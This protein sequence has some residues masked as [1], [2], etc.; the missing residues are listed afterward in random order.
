MKK[1]FLFSTGFLLLTAFVCSCSDEQ[2]VALQSD[3]NAGIKQML[4]NFN[5]QSNSSTRSTV[6]NIQI[7][8]IERQT[9]EMQGD[10]AV[11]VNA[12]VRTQTAQ[13]GA[14]TTFDLAY[15]S[16][17]IGEKKGF[18][19]LSDDERLNRVFFFTPNGCVADTAN[20][21]ALKEYLDYIPQFVAAEIHANPQ[22]VVTQQATVTEQI[23]HIVQTKWGQGEPFNRC[24]S[25]CA[26]SKCTNPNHGKIIPPIGCVN[27]AVAQYIAHCGKFLGTFY[28]NR[29]IDFKSL[30]S[31][32]YPLTINERAICARFLHEI[33]LCCQTYFTC[34]ASSTSAKA[35]YYYLRDLT[36]DCSYAEGGIDVSRLREELLKGYPHL[37]TGFKGKGESGHMWIIDG[38]RTCSDGTHYFWSNWGWNGDCNGW[39]DGTPYDALQKDGTLYRKYSYNLTHIYTNALP[40]Y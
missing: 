6:A 39:G 26:N 23:D 17:H 12:Q 37:I 24:A 4:E 15:V 3:N 40:N 13:N 36:Y 29:D 18:S 2:S 28:S 10:S 14:N 7:D 19:L 30:T 8:G 11:K 1:F 20:I 9:Y 5:G 34:D 27:I 16:F 25:S 35:A 38:L 32:T 31:H 21:P 22:R 33:A